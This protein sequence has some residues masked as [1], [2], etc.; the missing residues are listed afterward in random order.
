MSARSI[1]ELI[2]KPLSIIPVVIVAQDQIG[3]LSTVVGRSM[4]PTFNP[5]QSDGQ[6]S[7]DRVFVDRW[8]IR[9]QQFV[10]GDVVSLRYNIPFISISL[11]R[12][13]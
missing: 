8:S 7:H 13:A 2:W 12:I 6:Q 1:F 10:R 11:I 5:E 4:Q 3:H 9:R